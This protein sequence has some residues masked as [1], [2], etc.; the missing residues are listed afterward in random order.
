MLSAERRFSAPTLEIAAW[1]RGKQH[2]LNAFKRRASFLISAHLC[3]QLTAG[4]SVAR[5]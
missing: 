1:R 2:A 4:V 3:L 5:P